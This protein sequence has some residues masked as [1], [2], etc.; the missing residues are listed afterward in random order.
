MVHSDL[1][2]LIKVLRTPAVSQWGGGKPSLLIFSACTPG[3]PPKWTKSLNHRGL[4]QRDSLENEKP[5]V[6]YTCL[7]LFPSIIP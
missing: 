6:S 4:L 1:E 2:V 5:Q 3:K 7:V